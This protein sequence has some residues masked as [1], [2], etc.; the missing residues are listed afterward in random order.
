MA[1]IVTHADIFLVLTM[2]WHSKF[3]KSLGPIA[4]KLLLLS[5]A[6]T[7]FYTSGLEAWKFIYLVSKDVVV[8]RAGLTL[9][10]K[11]GVKILHHIPYRRLGTLTIALQLALFVNYLQAGFMNSNLLHIAMVVSSISAIDYGIRVVKGQFVV[12]DKDNTSRT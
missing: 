6:I 4:D 7:T 12:M 8:L 9:I 1:V 2:N 3:G 11:H 5:V 10:A